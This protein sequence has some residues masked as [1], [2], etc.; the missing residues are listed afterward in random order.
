MFFIIKEQVVLA[1]IW[2]CYV[3]QV[4]IFIYQ[5]KSKYTEFSNFLLF[6]IKM[7]L[8]QLYFLAKLATRNV[9][10][11][12]YALMPWLLDPYFMSHYKFSV[13]CRFQT[14]FLMC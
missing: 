3:D 1:V 8:L 10:I 7:Q 5:R 6:L 9:W 2:L 12:H 11:I 14:C 4:Y 13:K